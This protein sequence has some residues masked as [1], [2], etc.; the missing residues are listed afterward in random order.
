MTFVSGTRFHLQKEAL[1]REEKEPRQGGGAPRHPPAPIS[2]ALLW[3]WG[4]RWGLEWPS[5]QAGLL[6]AATSPFHIPRCAAHT[7][8]LS[9]CTEPN[10]PGCCFPEPGCPS[11]SPA[12][13]VLSSA[14]HSFGPEV[15]DSRVPCGQWWPTGHWQRGAEPWSPLVLWRAPQES[16]RRSEGC[17]SWRSYAGI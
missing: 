4:T 13:T 3:S 5:F 16:S 11:A 17:W 12:H 1:C 2:M 10:K 15:E 8:S 6:R 7:A 9:V 14:G